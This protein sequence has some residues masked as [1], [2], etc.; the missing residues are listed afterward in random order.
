VNENGEVFI[1][2]T[3]MAKP[4]KGKRINNFLRDKE[5]FEY[6]NALYD[7]KSIVQICAIVESPLIQ[8]IVGKVEMPELDSKKILPY[9]ILNG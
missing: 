2:A 1:N 7:E 8:V 9:V 4:F 6:I 3:E 5:F